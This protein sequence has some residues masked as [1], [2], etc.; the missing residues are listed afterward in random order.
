MNN[1]KLLLFANIQEIVGEHEISIGIPDRL[2]LRDF[3]IIF[4]SMYPEII[5]YADGLVYAINHE[6]AFDDDV[7]PEGAEIAIFPPVCGGT[8]DKLPSIVIIDEEVIDLNALIQK[9]SLG[10]TGAVAIFTGLV[11]SVTTRDNYHETAYL[12]Y[13]AYKPMAEKKAWQVIDEIR[14]KWPLIEGI[15]IVQ[16]I[17]TVYPGT[18]TVLIA[19]SAAH[20]DTGVFEAS[21]YGIDRLKEIVPVWKKEHGPQGKVWVEG[22]HFPSPND[23]S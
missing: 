22:G 4:V 21:K 15:A 1:V 5:E 20:R 18:P 6:F 7:I 17:G 12:E 9:I 14:E 11:R 2:M 8:A 19:C 13:H 23:R 10:S 3:K 16:R